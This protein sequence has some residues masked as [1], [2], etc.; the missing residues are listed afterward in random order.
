MGHEKGD[1]V[2]RRISP[3][4]GP[5]VVEVL[6]AVEDKLGVEA[7]NAGER[8]DGGVHVKWVVGIGWWVVGR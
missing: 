7:E 6:D 5:L 3:L 1:A 8:G 2:D 4:L